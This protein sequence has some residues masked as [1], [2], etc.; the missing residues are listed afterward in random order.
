MHTEPSWGSLCFYPSLWYFL[1][2]SE[3]MPGSQPTPEE[4][5]EATQKSK[6]DFLHLVDLITE[7]GT[8]IQEPYYLRV[9]RMVA[10][11]V[12]FQ[13]I[14]SPIL[15]RDQS[16]EM[17]PI[18]VFR[19]TQKIFDENKFRTRWFN[20]RLGGM[21]DCQIEVLTEEE[22]KKQEL[23]EKESEIRGWRGT[24][25]E[26]RAAEEELDAEDEDIKAGIAVLTES[27]AKEVISILQKLLDAINP[28]GP[29]G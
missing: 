20:L 1:C 2:M 26:L 14:Y 8:V 7:R 29:R 21:F 18:A 12:E 19:I 17:Q 27:E 11:G 9:A 28:P 15:P 6:D 22:F 5:M 13:A 10:E 4:K 23:K 24:E 25:G 16:D 3:R